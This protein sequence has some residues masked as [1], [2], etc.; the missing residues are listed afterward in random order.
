MFRNELAPLYRSK[1]GSISSV[2]F[3]GGEPI[4]TGQVI[5]VETGDCLATFECADS[6]LRTM[7]LTKLELENFLS[8]REKQTIDF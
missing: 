4:P 8:F 1:E 5:S 3:G 2:P 6:P 7:K